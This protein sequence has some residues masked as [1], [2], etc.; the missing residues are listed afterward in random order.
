[1]KV[2]LSYAHA[3][4]ALAERVCEALADSGLEVTDPDRDHLPGDNWAGEVAR[5]LEESEAMVVLLTPAA[6][7]SPDV[8][9]NIEFALG[10]KNYSNRLIPVVVGNLDRFPAA[11]LPWIVRRMPWFELNDSETE[12]PKVEPIA[13]AILSHA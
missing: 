4:A 13:E 8:K 12:P 7:S 1:M 11:E 2:F 10:A 9:R 5:A 3:D 6:V